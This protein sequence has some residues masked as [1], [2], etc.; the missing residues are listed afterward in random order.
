MTDAAADAMSFEIALRRAT[1]TKS[2]DLTKLL[3][4]ALGIEQT[5]DE[6]TTAPHTG[7]PIAL[8]DDAA[9]ARIIGGNNI[10]N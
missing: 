6:E 5:D 1:S 4:E 9:L 3:N 10:D 7:T 8:N 2:D